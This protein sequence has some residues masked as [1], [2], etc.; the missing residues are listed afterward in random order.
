MSGN[1]AVT[2]F[3]Y[4]PFRGD[5][6]LLNAGG[7]VVQDYHV[8]RL[9]KDYL[10]FRLTDGTYATYYPSDR[11]ATGLTLS[12][13]SLSLKTGE[14]KQLSVIVNPDGSILGGL[15]WT[16]GNPEVASVDPS[17]LVTALKGGTTTITVTTES[18]ETLSAQCCVD[19]TQLVTSISLSVTTLTLDI[20]G[21]TKLTATVLPADASDISITWSSSDEDVAEVNSKGVV[22][23]NGYGRCTITA[24]ANDGSGVKAE[25][26]IV[27]E[28]PHEY[29]DLGLPSGTLWATTN[30][31]ASEPEDYGYYFAWG[32]VEPKSTCNWSTYKWM[33]EGY[34][35]WEGC[36]KYT[37]ADG[38]TSGC[39][40]NNGTFVGDNKIELD[41]EDDAA[42][43]N[44]GEG[45]RMPSRAQQDELRDTNNC[46]WTWTNINGKNG[47]LVKSKRN[48][49]SLFLPAA[50]Y[51][52]GGSLGDAGS[53]GIYWS[54]SLS[55]SSSDYASGLGFYSGYIDWYIDGRYFGFSVRP[56]RVLAEL[57]PCPQRTN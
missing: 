4:F 36:N 3:E 56:V 38:Q 47:Y 28:K 15:T 31:G 7:Y 49:S 43:M 44:W 33:K 54:R 35:D 27:V 20:D 17:G 2:Q 39:W 21:Y 24:T 5:L 26:V 41:L 10:V 9:A 48:E 1:S 12:A 11:Y 45:W 18:G 14:T 29:V 13:T 8:L 51:R 6:V 50:G 57:S 19:V 46:T 22:T 37:I 16:S 23:V 55:P 30:V 32:E 25:C 34:S 42:Y 52:N 53:W 40:Y